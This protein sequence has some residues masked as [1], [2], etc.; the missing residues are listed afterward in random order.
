MA[1][2]RSLKDLNSILTEMQMLWLKAIRDRYLIGSVFYTVH[3][4]EWPADFI[5]QESHCTQI[6]Q[7]LSEVFPLPSLSKEKARTKFMILYQR[8]SYK[9]ISFNQSTRF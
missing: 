7:Y 5:G 2:E 4:A 3:W 6:S 9:S 8:L 1:A